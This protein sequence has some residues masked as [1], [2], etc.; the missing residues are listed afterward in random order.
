LIPIKNSPV[1]GEFFVTCGQYVFREIQQISSAKA[2]PSEFQSLSL[3]I[4]FMM[5]DSYTKKL[6]LS[7]VLRGP[8]M[9]EV[10]RTLQF[11]PGSKGL[12]VGCGIG[13]IT[14][15]LAASVMPTGHVT[16][17]DISPDMIAYARETAVKSGLSDQL[18]FHEEDMRSLSFEDETFDWA[19]SSDCVGYAPQETLPL[20]KEM[21][22]VIKPAGTIAILA[23][24][25][26]QLLPGYPALEA[27]LNATSAGIAPFGKNDNPKNHFL[28]TFSRFQELGLENARAHTFA[29]VLHAPLS[30]E[31]RKALLSLI[32]M[33][34]PGVQEELSRDDWEKYQLLCQPDSSEF[35]LNLPD[36]VTFFTYTLF[37]ASLPYKD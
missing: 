29:R 8:I 20:F 11:K 35:V 4:K 23:W 22:R 31:E 37:T 26:Q 30:G 9:R 5:N 33:R 1:P 28:R 14:S 25:S 34:W 10:I 27:R 16:G 32:Q 13:D 17:V 7:F 15:L 6:R 21:I 24:S 19:W 2:S 12:D 36:Y 18:S 3:I